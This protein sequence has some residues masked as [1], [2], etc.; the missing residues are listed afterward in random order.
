V[1][2]HLVGAG[3]HWRWER[4]RREL[5]NAESAE[6]VSRFDAIAVVN[7]DKREGTVGAGLQLQRNE[8]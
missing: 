6:R 5:G 8:S 3:R 4:R 7:G 1:D 2:E